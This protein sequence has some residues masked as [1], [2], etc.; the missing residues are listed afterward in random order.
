MEEKRLIGWGVEL[1]AAQSYGDKK[2][3]R[4]EVWA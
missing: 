1:Y 2:A 4:V 3:S